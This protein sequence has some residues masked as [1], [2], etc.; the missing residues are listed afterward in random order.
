LVTRE[1]RVMK[2]ILDGHPNPFELPSDL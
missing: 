1:E 2:N